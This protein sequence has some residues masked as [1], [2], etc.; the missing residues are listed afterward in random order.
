[1]DTFLVFV[2]KNNFHPLVSYLLFEEFVTLRLIVLNDYSK[3]CVKRPQKIDTTKILM[4]NG[5]LM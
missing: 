2:I 5:S 4:T 1:M 3:T